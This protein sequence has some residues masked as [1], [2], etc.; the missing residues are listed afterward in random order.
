MRLTII[1]FLL[2]TAFPAAARFLPG[3][4]Y[5]Y[6]GMGAREISLGG[7]GTAL[8]GNVESFSG[9]PASQAVHEYRKASFGLGALGTGDSLY[10]MATS[11]PIARGV[12]SFSAL[13]G[14]SAGLQEP[15]AGSLALLRGAFSKDITPHFLFGFGAG[16]G[17]GTL[18]PEENLRATLGFDLGFILR[19]TGTETEQRESQLQRGWGLMDGAF[20]LSFSH[21]G[22]AAFSPRPEGYRSFPDPALKVGW[23][24]TFFKHDVL[25][26]ASATDL[27]FPLEDWRV[28]FSS[29]LDFHFLESFHVRFGLLLGTEGAGPVSCGLSF[30]PQH[31]FGANAFELSYALLPVRFNGRN[32]ISHSLSVQ[33]PL[34]SMR[35]EPPHISLRSRDSHFSPNSDGSRD[36]ARF[37][38]NIDSSVKIQGWSLEIR[39]KEGRLV[40]CIGSQRSEDKPLTPGRFF[41]RLFAPKLRA[42]IP[43]AWQWDGKD[44]SGKTLPDG[45]YSY[46]AC[47]WNMKLAKGFSRKGAVTI[48]SR[49][50]RARIGADRTLFSPNG[51]GVLDKIE[52]HHRSIDQDARWE[53]RIQDTRGRTLRRWQWKQ[54]PSGRIFWDGR[55]SN[56]RLVADGDY[57]YLLSGRDKAGNHTK[58]VI[59]P[60]IVSTRKK[61]VNVVCREKRFAPGGKP[62]RAR[63]RPLIKDRRHLAHW[64]LDVLTQTGR[65]VRSFTGKTNVP[66]ELEWDGRDKQRRQV[67][68]G[69]YLFKLKAVFHDGFYP[70]SGTKSLQV[71]STPPR[72]Q[73]QAAKS[74]FSPDSDGRD[75]VLR[76]KVA[77]QDASPISRWRLIIR[78]GKRIFRSL[79]G[80]NPYSSSFT[81][82]WD[83]RSTK[84]ALVRSATHY[85]MQFEAWDVLGNH[86]RSRPQVLRTGILVQRDKGRRRI[87]LNR[88]D[89]VGSRLRHPREPILEDLSRVLRRYHRY[90][91][92]IL[93]SGQGAG[94]SRGRQ[95]LATLRAR[96]ILRY[97]ARTGIP[98]ERM[99]ATGFPPGAPEGPRTNHE[100][101]ED[102]YQ[103][104]LIPKD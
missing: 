10:H 69:C 36:T 31:W 6:L 2:L 64:R 100:E 80:R 24:F 28:R 81:V 59:S 57:R 30:H 45:S 67:P 98:R 103:F 42:S 63:F 20:G 52:I 82:R 27:T 13:F 76:I 29:G 77:L 89:F 35:L 23:A 54:L 90:N 68:D 37:D 72:I 18:Y 97:L 104:I 40:R 19:S 39:D 55:D 43:H 9:N 22:P 51:D 99:L 32:E 66:V 101:N 25:R 3:S 71:D 78:K 48:K 21:L 56:G 79:D 83:G 15:E 75:D 12:L 34:G 14:D 5:Y 41:K 46:Q 58:K 44:D 8:T 84:G 7:T 70:V 53:S 17:S 33:F 96:E 16:L 87:E 91:I 1:L 95:M 62:G 86:A 26:I 60:I 94:G 88:L 47:A 61:Q 102:P 74:G 50:P 49:P 4:Q 85:S 38:F 11:F 92:I 93:G 65:V 73:V